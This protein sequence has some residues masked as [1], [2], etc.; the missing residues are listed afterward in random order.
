MFF[1]IFSSCVCEHCW[2]EDGFSACVLGS[3]GGCCGLAWGGVGPG[4]RHQVGCWGGVGLLKKSLGVINTGSE[5]TILF[6]P[7]LQ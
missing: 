7:G 5:T 2:L 1:C 3:R 4:F 6:F